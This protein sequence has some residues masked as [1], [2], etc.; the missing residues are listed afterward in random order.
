MGEEKNFSK[1]VVLFKHPNTKAKAFAC[2]TRITTKN[3]LHDDEGNSVNQIIF[4]QHEKA[5]CRLCETRH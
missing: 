2:S 5:H 1:I 4:H 3:V